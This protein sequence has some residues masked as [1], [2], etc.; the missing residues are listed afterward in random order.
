MQALTVNNLQ[1]IAATN[2]TAAG[3]IDIIKK[4]REL[5]LDMSTLARL[6]S[7]LGEIGTAQTTKDK[8]VAALEAAKIISQITPNTADDK[9]VEA[10]TM[11]LSGKM[12]DTLCSLI[13]A[14]LGNKSLALD[15]VESEV[16][17]LGGKWSNFME[18]AKLVFQL[19][20]AGQG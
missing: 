5:N 3:L 13:D 6:M 18:L 1:H 17:A 10:A 9:I 7:L 4:M 12:L 11:V 15:A 8:V 2:I 19:I 20:R 14:W 16:T